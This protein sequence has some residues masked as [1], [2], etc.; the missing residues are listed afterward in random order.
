MLLALILACGDKEPALYEGDE[1]GECSDGADNDLDG[2]FDCNDEGCA[3]SPDCDGEVDTGD[4]DSTD[5]NDTN[6]TDTNDTDTND[7]NDTDTG[8]VGPQCNPGSGQLIAASNMPVQ[9]TGSLLNPEPPIPDLAGW[10]LAI[11]DLDNDGFDDLMIGSPYAAGGPGR[12]SIFYGPGNLWSS[13]MSTNDA[14]AYTYSAGSP[15]FAGSSMACG[16]INGDGADDL[17]IATGNGSVFG[18]GVSAGVYAF[19]N[20][21]T[22]L[23]GQTD[24]N[25]ADVSM[26]YNTGYAGSSAHFLY[27]W[28]MDADGDGVDEI[29]YFMNKNS[30]YG[31][32]AGNA[33]NKIWVLN[34]DANQQ[35]AM[36]SHIAYTIVPPEIDGVTDIQKVGSRLVIGQGAHGYGSAQNGRVDVINAPLTENVG[37]NTMSNATLTGSNRS[38]FG[39]SMA[40]ADFDQDGTTDTVIG[41]PGQG[42]SIYT[43][44]QNPSS[45]S[46]VGSGTGLS[47]TSFS[48]SFSG[49]G[50][51]H[52]MKALGSINDDDH[53]ELL[54]T[55]MGEFNSGDTGKAYVVD[56]LCLD[57]STSNLNAASLLQFTGETQ[58]DR[59]GWAT[60][61]GD[62]D[63]DGIP[64]IAISAPFFIPDPNVGP[65]YGMEG[66]VYLWLSSLE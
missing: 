56:G 22:R 26:F 63:G 46:G 25:T 21:G 41:A 10:S 38:A 28:V 2:L 42:G 13:A 44:Y 6:D 36:D 15:G 61:T 34:A 51:G 66:K 43:Y 14:D 27:L 3:G 57:G 52:S 39:A 23:S 35:G 33:D 37:L 58:N 8:E 45:F 62:I 18:Q 19:Y 40:F 59:F 64:D 32:I 7:T 24:I 31:D 11:C 20:N 12:V 9:I 60:A 30:F 48:S 1:A 54:V 29:L 16:D 50:I 49:F 4:T 65:Q 55:A 53:P 17:V 5:T 47:D